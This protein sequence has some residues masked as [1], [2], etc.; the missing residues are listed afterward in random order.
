MVGVCGWGRR[1]W[2][3]GKVRLPQPSGLMELWQRS[4]GQ[5]K[6]KGWMGSEDLGG[7]DSTRVNAGVSEVMF[8]HHSN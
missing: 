4:D 7:N 6:D 5:A 2:Y 3:R 8:D 1:P